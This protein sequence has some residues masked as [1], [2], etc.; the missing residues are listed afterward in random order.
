MA[1]KMIIVGAVGGGATVAAQIR[2]DN[3]DTTIILFDKNGYVSFSNCGMPYYLGKT[4]AN[5]NDILYPKDKFEEKYNVHVRTYAEVTA[6]D[7]KNKMITYVSQSKQFTETYDQLI[8]SPGATAV[9]PSI[10]GMNKMRTFNLHTIPDMDAIATFIEEK[11]PK[12]AAIIGG[13]FIGLEMLENLHERGIQCTLID[14]SDQVM[15]PIDD[16]MAKIVHQYVNNKNVDL[17]LNDRLQEFSNDGKTLH[18]NSGKVVEADITIMAVGIRPNIKLAKEAN[19]SIGKTE[20]IVVNEFM[21]TDDPAIYA[22][23]DAVETK[24]FIT[25]E[26]RNIA[27][28]WPAH[29][30][31]FII[32]N[33]INGKSIPYYGTIGSSILR[34]FD[35]TLGATGLNR[36]RLETQKIDYKEAK[37]ETLSS[38]G[39]FPGADKL[40]I[41]ILFDAANGRIYGGQV[42]GYA[43]ADK[44]LAILSTAIK[45]KLTVYD[46]PELELAYAPPYSSPKDPINILGYKAITLLAEDK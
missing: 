12:T 19:L 31:A 22:L 7:R 13:G 34:L 25:G 32:A 16:D 2:R 36:Y 30:Q 5:R 41:K 3:I 10:P 40:W 37:I 42:V 35:L 28:A 33:H 27:L 20:A 45:S 14:R 6:I 24:D 11:Q 43:G 15:N 26:P 46:L 23:G 44:R 39:Y 9:M 1:K 38:A 29:R 17:I 18:L 4:V 8:L 21:Q